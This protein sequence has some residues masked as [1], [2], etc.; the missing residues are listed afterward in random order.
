MERTC[1]WWAWVAVSGTVERS[2]IGTRAVGEVAVL[3]G[4]GKRV[5]AWA[6]RRS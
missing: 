3:L 2:G 5:A 6:V 1:T 4:E